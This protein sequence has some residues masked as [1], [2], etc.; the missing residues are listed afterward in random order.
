MNPP[1]YITRIFGTSPIVPLQKHM[2]KA[3][4]CAAKLPRFIEASCTG[5]WERAAKARRKIVKLENDADELKRE[6]RLNLPSSLFMAINRSD[7][8]ELLS[9]QDRI[10]NTAKDISGLITGRR[11]V[12]PES[13]Q[14]LYLDFLSRSL[15]AVAQARKSVNELERLFESGFRGAAVDLIMDM[16]R[17]LSQIETETDQLQIK[18]RAELYKIEHEL[19]PVDAIFLYKIIDWTGDLS[20]LS[21]RVSSRLHLMIAR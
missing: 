12:L 16:T 15:D 3:A 7:A 18:V 19:P 9:I 17:E 4:K 20:G 14:P 1:G 6:L 8:L 10:A 2:D 5:D 21:Q 13:I 11:M